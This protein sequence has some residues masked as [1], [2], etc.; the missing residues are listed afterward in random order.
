[1]TSCR[2][3]TWFVRATAGVASVA[4]ATNAADRSLDLV[5]SFLHLANLLLGCLITRRE[6]EP[7]YSGTRQPIFECGITTAR[8]TRTEMHSGRLARLGSS[9]VA[10]SHPLFWVRNN[11]GCYELSY[12][13]SLR[14]RYS[15]HDLV[16]KWD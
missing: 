6:F 9:A 8:V 14:T 12:S 13:L 1:M 3:V 11:A 10:R 16:K 15:A 7:R 5:T 4:A 2:E